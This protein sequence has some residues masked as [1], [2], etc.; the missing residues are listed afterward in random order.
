MVPNR[1]S[2]AVISI[3]RATRQYSAIFKKKYRTGLRKTKFVYN[4]LDYVGFKYYNALPYVGAYGD[5][6]SRAVERGLIMVVDKRFRKL[7]QLRF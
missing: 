3:D 7:D 6:I 1:G 2:R 4:K 5:I